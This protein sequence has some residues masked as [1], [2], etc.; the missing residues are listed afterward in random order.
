MA[1][2]AAWG[3]LLGA[4]FGFK[5]GWEERGH[6]PK[7]LV[8]FQSCFFILSPQHEA[9]LVACAVDGRVRWEHGGDCMA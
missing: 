5:E 2:S 6:N 7:V 3:E 8:V 4:F 1:S 9:P